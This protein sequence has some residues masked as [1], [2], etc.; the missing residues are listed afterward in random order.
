MGLSLRV[1]GVS[2]NVVAGSCEVAGNGVCGKVAGNSR[3]L[4][5]GNSR[6]IL[7]KVKAHVNFIKK[8]NF[9]EILISCHE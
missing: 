7:K 2:G 1:T 6:G 8:R 5:P 4:H 3:W 9:K